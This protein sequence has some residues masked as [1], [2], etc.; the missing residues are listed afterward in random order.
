[1]PE[2]VEL[3]PAQW[4][5]RFLSMPRERQE[6]WAEHITRAVR[7]YNQCQY[8]NHKGVITEQRERIGNLM[9]KTRR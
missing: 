3:T 6:L 1:M 4:V 5:D 8:E 7:E 2:C 9:S